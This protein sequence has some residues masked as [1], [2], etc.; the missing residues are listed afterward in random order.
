MIVIDGR[1]SEL[2]IKNF[3]NLEQLFNKVV[4]EG[5][6]TDRVVTDVL[7]ND[8][9]F[10]EIY[11]NQSEDIDVNEVESVEIRTIA[12]DQMAINITG[13]LYKVV[14]LMGDGARAWPTSSARPMTPRPWR[15]TRT[16]WT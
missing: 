15:C 5:L 7:V 14:K 12:S 6:L 4:E 8:E 16:C 3:Q 13:E 11:P 2:D 9:P 1:Q 10:S